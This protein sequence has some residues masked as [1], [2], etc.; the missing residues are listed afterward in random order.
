MWT[1][2][3]TE[4]DA[5]SSWTVRFMMV[6]STITTFT[7]KVGSWLTKVGLYVWADQRQYQ[8][9]WHRNKMHGYGLTKWPDGRIYEGE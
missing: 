1:G 9:D 4:R 6:I 2:A 7:E 3:N 5:W 8:G